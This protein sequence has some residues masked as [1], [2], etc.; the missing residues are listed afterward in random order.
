[1]NARRDYDRTGVKQGDKN[2]QNNNRQQRG[3]QQQPFWDFFG[4]R[5][6]QQPRHD[7]LQHHLYRRHDIR[8]QVHA[9]QRR[10]SNR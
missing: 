6:H 9:A 10:V 7:P 4:R 5:N 3:G 2:Q 1:V 8:T